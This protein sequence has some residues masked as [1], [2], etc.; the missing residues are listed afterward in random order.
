MVSEFRKKKF[1]HVFTTFF[2]TDKSGTITKEDFDQAT[3][4]VAE[5]KGWAD[6]DPD[7]EKI[8][9]GHQ[10][11][12]QL[13]KGQADADDD[14]VITQDEWVTMWDSLIKDQGTSEPPEWAS[15][16]CKYMFQFIDTGSDDAI[17]EKEFVAAY[18]FYGFSEEDASEAF[19]KVSSGKESITFEEFQ[20]LWKEFFLSEDP[21]APGNY[22]YG[23]L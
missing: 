22:I 8:K 4:K 18:S 15:R 5:V 14:G 2:D 17:D 7:F 20:E 1:I 13:L 11:V 6:G 19:K 23:P 9:D 16:N 12:W 21:E 10:K 3:Q